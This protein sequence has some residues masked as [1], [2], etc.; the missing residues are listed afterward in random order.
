[1]RPVTICQENIGYDL[2]SRVKCWIVFPNGTPVLQGQFRQ[3]G[4]ADRIKLGLRFDII[5][6]LSRGNS[7]QRILQVEGRMARLLCLPYV[8]EALATDAAGQVGMKL[9]RGIS[10]AA[11]GSLSVAWRFD[12]EPRRLEQYLNLRQSLGEEGVDGQACSCAGLCSHDGG[13]QRY[14]WRGRRFSKR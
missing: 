6:D 12:S 7:Y 14:W 9:S 2:A 13:A 11:N 1:M 8:V 10:N 4:K 3:T 5:V